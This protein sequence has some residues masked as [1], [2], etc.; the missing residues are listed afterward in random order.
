MIGRLLLVVGSALL[1]LGLVEVARASADNECKP[2]VGWDSSEEDEYVTPNENG[3]PICAYYDC[4]GQGSCIPSTYQEGGT[5]WYKCRCSSWILDPDRCELRVKYTGPAYGSSPQR[6]PVDVECKDNCS[7][8][9]CEAWDAG[10][11]SHWTGPGAKNGLARCPG[12]EPRG[13]P[14]PR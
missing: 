13:A 12:C 6:R 3:D 11:S 8:G 9:D 2:A 10:S 4:P 5:T 7:T 1:V 14:R